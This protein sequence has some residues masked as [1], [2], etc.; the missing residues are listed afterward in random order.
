MDFYKKFIAPD[1]DKN[2]DKF[3]EKEMNDDEKE[4]LSDS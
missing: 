4:I 1:L 2:F 3:Y